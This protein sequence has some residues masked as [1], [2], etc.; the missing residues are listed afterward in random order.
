MYSSRA[1]RRLLLFSS[2]IIRRALRYGA[3]AVFHTSAHPKS[4]TVA[5]PPQCW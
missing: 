3:D 2:S 1:F 5:N 4:R